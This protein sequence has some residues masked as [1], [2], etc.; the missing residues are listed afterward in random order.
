M[1]DA[2]LKCTGLRQ[3]AVNY[4]KQRNVVTIFYG[5]FLD[6]FQGV[7]QS[8]AQPTGPLGTIKTVGNLKRVRLTRNEMGLW[9]IH[10]NTL[11]A[12]TVKVTGAFLLKLDFFFL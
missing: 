4:C 8:S 12:Y 5:I 10:M 11:N 2:V 3:S 9:K 7:S 6:L 1:L